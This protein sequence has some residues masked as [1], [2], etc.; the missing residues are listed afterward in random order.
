MFDLLNEFRE[1]KKLEVTGA[2]ILPL[3]GLWTGRIWGPNDT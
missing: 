1:L 2:D 3:S